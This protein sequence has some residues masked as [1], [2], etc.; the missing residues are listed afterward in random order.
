MQISGS[1]AEGLDMKS[2]DTDI[3]GLIGNAYEN[4]CENATEYLRFR[5]DSLM[6]DI[7]PG[8]VLVES[9]I[10]GRVSGPFGSSTLKN[11]IFSFLPYL[12]SSFT[13]FPHGPSIS[14]SSCGDDID[15]VPCLKCESWPKIARA[16]KCFGWPSQEMINEIVKQG[17]YIVPVGIKVHN[18]SENEWRLSFSLAEKYLIFTFNHTQLMIYGMLK[19]I[20]KEIIS[21]HE[22]ISELFCYF[23]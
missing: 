4:N 11:T 1:K 22:D 5:Y 19:I 8:Y 7:H 9:V 10:K 20:L 6:P 17:C 21:Q 12:K 14:N 23:F 13:T 2:S 16:W 15:L 3:M 18:G